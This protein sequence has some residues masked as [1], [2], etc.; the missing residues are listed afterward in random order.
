MNEMCD[1][2]REVLFDFVV[3]DERFVFELHNQ[4][5]AGVSIHVFSDGE[6]WLTSPP[7]ARERAV[8]QAEDLRQGLEANPRSRR[9]TA[10]HEAAHAIA[11]LHY[12]TGL[13]STTIRRRGVIAGTTV[14]TPPE[15]LRHVVAILCGP[16][17]ENPWDEFTDEVHLEGTDEQTVRALRLAPN[18]RIVSEIEAAAFMT[19]A[20]VRRQIDCV[21][22]ALLERKTLTA[23]EV[24][25]ISG[26]GDRLCSRDWM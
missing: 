11:A 10:R 22:Q 20:E 17:A 18:Q 13:F 3:A 7:M 19:N 8:Q 6:E 15:T 12:D 23:D 9:L 25:E 4:G 26:F 16:L 14:T 24:R 21:A 5:E 1:Q 2:P